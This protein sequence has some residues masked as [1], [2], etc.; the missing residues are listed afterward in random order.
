[1]PTWR[2]SLGDRR[3]FFFWG[4]PRE[5]AGA[6]ALRQFEHP[7][8]TVTGILDGQ[9]AGAQGQATRIGIV[10]PVDWVTEYRATHA[11][12]VAPDLVA[13]AGL[14]PGLNQGV[15]RPCVQDVNPGACRPPIEGIIEPVLARVPQH[16][17]PV[18]LVHLSLGELIGQRPGHGPIGGHDH[19]SEGFSVQAMDQEG[20]GSTPFDLPEE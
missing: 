9:V 12:Q 6:Q 14:D 5:P 7:P 4:Q 16:Q 10:L 2:L 15:P 18:A 19:Q 11:G 1:M 17:D 20:A 13:A 3:L 8:I